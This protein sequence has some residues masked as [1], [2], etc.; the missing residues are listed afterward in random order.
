L[1]LLYFKISSPGV[2]A[3]LIF[4]KKNSNIEQIRSKVA[5]FPFLKE[6]ISL[7]DAGGTDR[8][9]KNDHSV[10]TNKN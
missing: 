3:L 1:S 7:H 2:E 8:N 10:V 4:Q 5:N 6:I 9:G